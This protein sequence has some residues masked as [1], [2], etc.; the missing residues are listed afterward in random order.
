MSTMES[1]L[2]F[3]VPVSGVVAGFMARQQGRKETG[4]K[5][6]LGSLMLILG[7]LIIVSIYLSI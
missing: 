5:M 2:C 4:N 1:F 7:S 3:F 6:I